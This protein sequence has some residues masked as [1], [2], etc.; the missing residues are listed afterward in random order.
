M[1]LRYLHLSAGE[2]TVIERMGSEG[3]SIREIARRLGRSASTV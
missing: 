3:A 2:R 1:G